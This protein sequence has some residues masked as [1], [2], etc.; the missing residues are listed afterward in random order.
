M[1]WIAAPLAFPNGAGLQQR[2]RGVGVSKPAKK[3]VRISDST[4]YLDDAFNAQIRITQKSGCKPAT[5][6]GFR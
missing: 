4:L 6:S 2:Q 1:P 5:D 3:I